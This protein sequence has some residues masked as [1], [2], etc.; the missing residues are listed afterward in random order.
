VISLHFVGY[1]SDLLPHL[2][3]RQ[4]A[5]LKITVNRLE[6]LNAGDV[7]GPFR[8][9]LFPGYGAHVIKA[10]PLTAVIPHN[11][12]PEIM[13]IRDVLCAV[14]R[15]G[16]FN[17]DLQAIRAGV[18]PNGFGYDGEPRTPGFR[19]VC[20]PGEA[21][22]VLLVLEDGQVAFGDCV[23][24]IFTGAAGRD[25]LFQAREHLGV[26]QTAVCDLLH[27]RVCDTFAPLAAEVDGYRH[28]GVRLHTALRYGISQALLHAASL[29][30]RC[31]AAEVVAR[32]YQCGIADRP[33]P[34]LGMCPT[35]QLNQVDK[36][37]MKRVDMLPHGSFAN[38]EQDVGRRG[39][40]LL[41]Y[42]AWVARR[43]RELGEPD[44][45]PAIH[46]DVYGTLGELFR[47]DIERIADFLVQLQRQVEPLELFIETPIIAASRS[48]QIEA[49]RGL[50]AALRQRGHVVKLVADEW[51]NTL[52]DI[53]AF[54]DAAAADYLQVKTPDLGGIDKTIEALLYCREQGAGLY[55][56]GS[57]NETE[58]SARLCA[59]IALACQADF[60]MC[61][62]GQGADEGL[63]ILGN[64]MQRT[65]TLL[66]SRRAS[67]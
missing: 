45:R 23:D 34:I 25:P 62:P 12:G 21:I 56:G 19:R 44:Y 32:E 48:A 22:S 38:L 29:A 1:F 35:D 18:R 17:K 64:E 53:Q 50:R 46:L 47:E 63:L 49:F 60:M 14:G 15:S 39:E 24:V 61:K 51:C 11:T 7:A 43:I 40:K 8:T 5:A 58:Q 16:Y 9:K 57:A 10:G 52:E 42:A 37:I 30:N 33:I 55:L 13:K 6:G 27:H 65:L 4:I 36:M 41:D 28:H 67:A 26:L 66:R 2:W 31:T 59:H 3:S 54:A 20:Q